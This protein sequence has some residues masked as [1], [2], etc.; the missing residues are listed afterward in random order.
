MGRGKGFAVEARTS[1][2]D[3]ADLC[4]ATKASFLKIVGTFLERG[5]LAP[6]ELADVV[7]AKAPPSRA[8]EIKRAEELLHQ[9]RTLQSD[10]D[11]ERRLRESLQFELAE[12][13]RDASREKLMRQYFQLR[14]DHLERDVEKHR[15]ALKVLM[16]S[17]VVGAEVTVR[18][19]PVRPERNP[20]NLK[21]PRRR[22]DSPFL[23]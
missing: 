8:Q 10:L 2:L 16:A 9:A 23:E 4:R 11:A 3:D 13:E 17:A 12:L 7:R 18:P 20:P 19:G 5:H 15:R 6:Q 22:L 21:T 14:G 1:G